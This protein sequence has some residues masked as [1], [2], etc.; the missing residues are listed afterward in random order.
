MIFWPA[1]ARQ[2]R[3]PDAFRG[4]A[5]AEKVVVGRYAGMGTPRG[6]SNAAQLLLDPLHALLEGE[7]GNRE[8]IEP[9]FHPGGPQ[10]IA[11][12]LTSF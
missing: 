4:G 6:W 5:Q 12:R 8:V 1:V 3:D 10:W 2:P 7:R 9:G 11:A